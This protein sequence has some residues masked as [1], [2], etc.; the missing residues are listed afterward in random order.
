MNLYHVRQGAEGPWR[1]HEPGG[2]G[3]GGLLM[4][5]G[6]EIEFILKISCLGC[7]ICQ[8]ISLLIFSNLFYS[9]DKL[10]IFPY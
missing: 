3:T 7:I 8:A 10:Y 1:G 4:T 5:Q 9:I 2:E 6:F